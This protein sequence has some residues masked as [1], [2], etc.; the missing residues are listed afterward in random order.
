MTFSKEIKNNKEFKVGVELL[1]VIESHGFDAFFVGGC[2]RDL[3][4]GHESHDVDISTNAPIELLEEIFDTHDIG[5]SKDFGIVVVNLKGFSFEVAQFRID[6]N[7]SDGRRPDS[8][9]ITNSFEEDVKRRDFTINALGMDKDGNVLDFVG[10]LDDMKSGVLRSVGDPVER[11]TEDHLRMLRAVRFASRFDFEIE[12][13]TFSAIR[14]LKDKVDLV[15]KERVK[16]ELSKMASGDGVLFEKGIRLLD[17]TRLL[18]VILPEVKSLQDV[19]EDVL[20]HPEAHKFGNGTSFDHVMESLKRNNKKDSLVNFSVLF[21]DLGKAVC[22]TLEF[23]PKHEKFCHRFNG[24]GEEGVSIIENLCKRLKFTN[25]EKDVFTF[26]SKEH[27]VFF[28]TG[29]KMKKSTI[30]KHA[31]HEH[32]PV[33]R[34]VMFCDDSCRGEKFDKDK[35][36]KTMKEIDDVVEEFKSF[37]K[38]GEVKLLDGRVVME[39][40]GLKPSKLLGDVMTEAT[41]RFLNSKEFVC[42]SRMVKE[43]AREMK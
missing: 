38:G 6:S 18:E 26:V 4:M 9:E 43:V 29:S 15:S 27:M 35:F 14:M 17:N 2:V 30:V 33:L 36:D 21:H 41:E 20:F 24:H 28:N 32:F 39:L 5:K 16:D 22:H 31:T 12:P 13:N 37:K 7:D 42:M 8:V 23:V 40:T 34:E 10:G 3:V 25:H 19:Q 1:T 11:F